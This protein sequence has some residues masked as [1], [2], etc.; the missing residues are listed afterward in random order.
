MIPDDIEASL[1]SGEPG[2]D[3]VEQLDDGFSPPPQE[4]APGRPQEP[5]VPVLTSKSPF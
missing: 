4:P 1:R 2:L 3:R 5:P